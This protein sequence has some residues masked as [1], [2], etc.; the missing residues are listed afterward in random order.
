MYRREST[1]NSTI[2]HNTILYSVDR[3]Y[4][5]YTVCT[6]SIYI[7]IRDLYTVFYFYTVYLLFIICYIYCNNKQT[8]YN[9]IVHTTIIVYSTVYTVHTHTVKIVETI[10]KKSHRNE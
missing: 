4:R 8:V 2:I 10:E 6:F 7:S 1:I 3:N 9:N 5:E